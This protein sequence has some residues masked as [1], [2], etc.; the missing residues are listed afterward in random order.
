MRSSKENRALTSLDVQRYTLFDIFT[1]MSMRSES[2]QVK[3]TGNS[4][5]TLQQLKAHGG[6]FAVTGNG[7]TDVYFA[8]AI[9]GSV[10]SEIQSRWA[11]MGSKLSGRSTA[12][13]FLL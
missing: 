5:T 3:Q 11:A 8:Q 2:L 7:A 6:S 4:I 10:A 1:E 9:A 13:V 12:S